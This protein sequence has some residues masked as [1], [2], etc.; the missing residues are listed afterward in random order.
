[1]DLDTVFRQHS[2]QTDAAFEDTTIPP[3]RGIRQQHRWR[4]PQIAV[5][6]VGAAA[7]VVTLVL[8]LP[9]QAS[10]PVAEESSTTVSTATTEAVAPTTSATSAPLVGVELIATQ[11]TSHSLGSDRLAVIGNRSISYIESQGFF[12]AGTHWTVGNDWFRGR[13]WRSEDGT[14]WG[15]VPGSGTIFPE[16]VGLA[17][18]IGREGALVTW[19]HG[20]TVDP[21]TTVWTSQDGWAWTVSAHIP[22]AAPRRGLVLQSGDLLLWGGGTEG[23]ETGF[24]GN[25]E[26]LASTD[27]VSWEVIPVPVPFTAI[28]RLDSGRLVATGG[29]ASEPMTWTSTDGRAW[30]LLSADHSITNG[31]GI[32]VNALV[33]AGPGLVA[34]GTNAEGEAAL[35]VST[36]GRVF[37]QVAGFEPKGPQGGWP[38]MEA[39][40]TVSDIAVGREWLVAVGDYGFGGDQARGVGGGAIWISQDGMGWDP[41]PVELLDRRATSLVDVAYGDSIFVVTGG[42]GEE[43][44]V[45]TWKPSSP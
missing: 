2:E 4:G 30:T 40:P 31:T 13:L 35:W 10:L 32:V 16:R 8:L 45:L 28:V 33:A 29:Q 37:E 12:I 36:D 23:P 9:R 43:P 14:D 38:N 19:G 15:V 22:A 44:L 20:V 27:A 34:G 7:V 3:F 18:V 24:T 6:M 42:R 17:D 21:S 41:V 26:V 1:M 11:W 5:A 25:P 39:P